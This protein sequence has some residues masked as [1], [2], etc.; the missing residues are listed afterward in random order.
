[1]IT[2]TPI[3]LQQIKSLIKAD[4]EAAHIKGLRVAIKAGGCAGYSYQMEFV[5]TDP[6]PQDKTFSC[7]DLLI[8]VDARSLLFIQGL[9]IDFEGG[10]NG[11]GFTYHNPNAVRGCGCGTSF[12]V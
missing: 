8:M 7:E 1:M 10:L 11:S 12:S 5:K 4:P 3:A 9:E 2:L 6:G